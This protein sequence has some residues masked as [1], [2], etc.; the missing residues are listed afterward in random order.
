VIRIREHMSVYFN[1]KEI[2]SPSIAKVVKNVSEDVT[3]S[4]NEHGLVLVVVPVVGHKFSEHRLGMAV[5]ESTRYLEVP[6][7]DIELDS[8]SCIRHD[9]ERR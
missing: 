3:V 5:D 1:E 6:S 8:L 2:S 9:V 7:S 4:I